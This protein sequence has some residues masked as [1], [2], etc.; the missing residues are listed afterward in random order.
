MHAIFQNNLQELYGYGAVA[1]VAPV[2]PSYGWGSYLMQQKD[3][4]TMA[5]IK[6]P[7]GKDYHISEFN[8]K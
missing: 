6:G 2:A 1:P 7:D 4:D 8:E 5:A 3:K